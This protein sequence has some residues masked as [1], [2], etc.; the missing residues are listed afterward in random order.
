MAIGP[1]PPP[2]SSPSSLGPSSP[3]PVEVAGR[4]RRTQ[5]RYH[6]VGA[7]IEHQHNNHLSR[8]DTTCTDTST[9]KSGSNTSSSSS[10]LQGVVSS[11]AGR[12][13]VPADI[14]SELDRIGNLPG[15]TSSDVLQY[16]S[17]HSYYP[18]YDSGVERLIKIVDD[19]DGKQQE[20]KMTK[21]TQHQHNQSSS[22]SLS[23]S[24]LSSTAKELWKQS[25]PTFAASYSSTNSGIQ[26]LLKDAEIGLPPMM[27]S[28]SEVKSK[29][30]WR[31]SYTNRSK[32][33]FSTPSSFD[34]SSTN[35][36]VIERLR[37]WRTVGTS[38]DGGDSSTKKRRS[39]YHGFYKADHH[40]GMPDPHAYVS[41]YIKTMAVVALALSQPPPQQEELSSTVEKQNKTRRILHF[42][43]GAG[44]LVRFLA[45]HGSPNYSRHLAIELDEGVVKASNELQLLS[46]RSS[47]DGR[48]IRRIDDNINIELRCG[49]A[50]EYR[51]DDEHPFDCICIDVFDDEL[52]VPPTFYS[53]D[54]L[55]RLRDDI[56]SDSSSCVIQNF[57]SGGKKRTKIL[58]DAIAAYRR[59][60][61]TCVVIKSLDS[62][63]HAGNTILV[64]TKLKL[65][66]DDGT[67][68]LVE[69]ALRCE[70]SYELPFD[71]IA[72]I[73]NAVCYQKKYE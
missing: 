26:L 16:L 19:C 23:L 12:L 2:S 60:F 14:W 57:H 73:Q 51:N 64:G 13:G 38:T 42:G 3:S 10:S 47:G 37:G 70:A 46:L 52:A 29:E 8:N 32:V 39:I 55:E 18:I 24:S 49:D 28:D 58:N 5:Q 25:T 20:K 65:E 53:T 71:A 33:L 7:G 50:L 59:V 44:T 40:L 21:K 30:S 72:R 68:D 34:P 41:E 22:S 15:S 36:E 27:D 62:K 1:S 54:F 17:N 63:I 61:D 4:R 66:D 9:T 69:K 35:V 48:S 67:T 45:Y 31:S 11:T 43:F 6:L 56:L